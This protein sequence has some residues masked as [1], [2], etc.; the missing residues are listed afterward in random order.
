MTK[1]P[2]YQEYR[3]AARRRHRLRMMVMFAVL[4]A[5]A[6]IVVAGCA[7]PTAPAVDV[8]KGCAKGRTDCTPSLVP[9]DTIRH[10]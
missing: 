1:L 6:M 8:A 7:P 4:A 10:P 3:I 9:R 5:A 2:D